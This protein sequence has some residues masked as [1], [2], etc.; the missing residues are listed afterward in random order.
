MTH[1]SHNS[2]GGGAGSNAVWA[3]DDVF[4]WGADFADLFVYDIYPY[5][6]EDYRVGESGLVYRPRMSQFHWTIA[7]MRNLTATYGK[8]LGFWVGTFN[9]TWFS[10]FQDDTRRNQYWMEREMAYSAIAGGADYLITGFNVPVDARHWEDFG[11]G[12]NVIQKR[13]GEITRTEVP[14]A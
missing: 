2:L 14:K 12:M 8:K 1:D 11:E 7:Q 3:V 13:G 4:H 10:R 6:A 9:P 5:T